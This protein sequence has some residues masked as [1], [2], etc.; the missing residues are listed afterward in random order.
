MQTYIVTDSEQGKTEIKAEDAQYAQ[1]IYIDICE[2]EGLVH[3]ELK[4][5]RIA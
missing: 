3:G 2:A 1:E 4:I 5:T